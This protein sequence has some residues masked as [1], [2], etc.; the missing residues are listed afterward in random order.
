VFDTGDQADVSQETEA[1]FLLRV[2]LVVSEPEMQH[3]LHGGRSEAI[4]GA[5]AF[6]VV[7]EP[8]RSFTGAEETEGRTFYRRK[9]RCSRMGT[10]RG[11]M[12]RELLPEEHQIRERKI[13][14]DPTG[15][16]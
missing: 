4:R 15:G 16:N 8:R 2:L 14:T 7:G 13:N 9:R 5:G 12:N 6:V 1:G 3:E 10:G 11:E